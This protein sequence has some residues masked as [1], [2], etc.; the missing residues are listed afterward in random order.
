MEK[1]IEH[2]KPIY[3]GCIIV[4]SLFFLSFILT[5]GYWSDDFRLWFLKGIF[6][7]DN[8]TIFDTIHDKI[9]WHISMGRIFPVTSIVSENLVYLLPLK[10]YKGYLILITILCELSCFRAIYKI[11]ANE[12]FAF[13]STISSVILFCI[14]P[15]YVHSVFLCFGGNSILS[16]TLCFLALG[17]WVDWL[18]KGQTKYEIIFL[19][20][21][22]LSLL[23]YEVAYTFIIVY[24]LI[25]AIEKRNIR[26]IIKAIW[27]TAVIFLLVFS[28][29]SYVKIFLTTNIY[30][31]NS[32]SINLKQNL[33]GF[34]VSITSALPFFSWFVRG[35]VEKSLQGF[36][37]NLSISLILKWLLLIGLFVSVMILNYKSTKK[38]N[39]KRKSN[40][41]SSEV[42]LIALTC[43][44]F[45]A[46]L[47]A[48][49]EKYQT[50]DWGKG[51]IVI[52]YQY[53]GLGILFASIFYG[54]VKRFSKYKRI[55]YAVL[56][57]YGI[58]IITVNQNNSYY[59]ITAMEESGHNGVL[60]ADYV[61]LVESFSKSDILHQLS[62]NGDLVCSNKRS[63]Y[64]LLTF[65][66]YDI[67]CVDT[68]SE[69][70]HTIEKIRLFNEFIIVG[71][72]GNKKSKL[73]ENPLIYYSSK[74]AGK[75]I[76]L[77]TSDGTILKITL[78]NTSAAEKGYCITRLEGITAFIDT[79]KTL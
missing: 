78:E 53:F 34:F 69:T 61:D 17:S 46:C 33:R 21:F 41:C 45:P 22:A 55:W 62:E 26:A 35:G 31:G 39:S 77:K 51:Y 59:N 30:A 10:L 2:R 18:R 12:D 68:Y 66:N 14:I 6:K 9:T 40:I 24:F 48:V 13:L 8:K 65:S 52:I 58:C 19:V 1:I 73:V 42:L 43:I 67:Q 38:N 44:L 4:F 50:L 72:T 76:R 16:L 56:L 49:S 71:E 20:L 79:P 27:K 57:V 28:L 3:I 29:Y 47:M 32:L 23:T 64:S 36:T 37:A 5:S 54:S 63:Q 70:S 11:S 15:D 60:T 7:A 75:Q 25:A 74:M